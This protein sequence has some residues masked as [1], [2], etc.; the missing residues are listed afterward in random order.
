[1]IQNIC[2]DARLGR[3]I[4]YDRR[5]A[6]YPIAAILPDKK[7]R[8][9]KWDCSVVL[10]QGNL[11]SCVGN[12]FAHEL[13]AR[14][15]VHILGQSDA[16]KIYRLAQ[17]MDPWPGEDYEG[18]SVLAGVKATQQLY[19]KWIKEYRWA[20]TLDDLI[21]TLGY[22]GPVVL[23]V[24]WYSGF[25]SPDSNGIIKITGNV[26]GGHCILANGVNIKKKLIQLHNSWGKSYGKNGNAFISFS[27]M[28]K[29]LNQGADACVLVRRG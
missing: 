21:L 20:N 1:M 26:V 16:V 23:G 17:T 12:G 3:L 9:Y 10:D 25:Y 5:N 19:P 2:T 28:Q 13:I 14:P 22:H 27:D 7:P 11:G 18:T 4:E 6:A 29:L 15:K 24:A 8:S